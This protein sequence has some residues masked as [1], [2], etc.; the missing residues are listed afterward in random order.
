MSEPEI[1]S[2][3]RRIH[4]PT[5]PG[6]GVR[7]D[8]TSPLRRDEIEAV[9][10]LIA[11]ART[12]R[13]RIVMPDRL[14][15]RD[16]ESVMAVMDRTNEILDWPSGGWKIGAASIDVQRAEGVPGPAPGQIRRDAVFESPARLPSS[17]F[18]NYRCA[19]SEFAF[20][21]GRALPAK[22]VAFSEAEVADAVEALLPALEIGDTVFDDWYGASG[23]LGSLMDNG[24]AA[25]LVVGS[26]IPDW[27]S[28]DLA[29]AK[30]DLSLNGRLIKSGHGR[31]AMGH[32]L[33]SLTWMANWLRERGRQLEAGHIVSTGTCTGHF[34]V[35]P[36][37]RLELDYGSIGRLDVVFE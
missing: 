24:G 30:V 32:P 7:C 34:F 15:T 27:R 3:G 21:M 5:L 10:E 28:L 14:R 22:D 6:R 35:Q 17:L 36:G 37:D 9:A 18:I 23:Y 2:W 11:R 19:E 16:W 29:N 33:T 20:R 25:A 4:G 1:T 13:S 12:E 26:P 31:A 8:R